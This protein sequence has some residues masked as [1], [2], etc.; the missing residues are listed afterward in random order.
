MALTPSRTDFHATS[1]SAEWPRT[2]KLRAGDLEAAR[3]RQNR[4]ELIDAIADLAAQV[5]DRAKG[6]G[7]RSID[8]LRLRAIIMVLA[9]AGWDGKSQPGAF[10]ALPPSGDTQGSWPRLIGRALAAL[11]G[12]NHPA[13]RT[14]RI[15]GYYETIPDDILVCWATCMWSIHAVIETCERHRENETL[16]KSVRKLRERIYRLTGLRAE[17]FSDPRVL[18]VF[19]AMS[20]RFAGRLDLDR[21]EIDALHRRMAADLNAAGGPGF[22]LASTSE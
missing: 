1:R 18:R 3:R 21:V 14:L 2:P 8:I 17:E 19:D 5:N 4:E 15:D 22:Q 7:L 16:L 9:A 10:Q 13:I 11:F 6:D 20:A 12:G